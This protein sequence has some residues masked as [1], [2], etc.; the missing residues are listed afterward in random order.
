MFKNRISKQNNKQKKEI[1][2]N[3]VIQLQQQTMNNKNKRIK[4]GFGMQRAKQQSTK[5]RTPKA[6]PSENV[7]QSFLHCC[8]CTS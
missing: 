7:E 3:V 2:K 4:I 6:K 5:S 1:N 8:C